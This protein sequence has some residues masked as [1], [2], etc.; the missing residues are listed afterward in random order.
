M[1]RIVA[2]AGAAGGVGTTSITLGL[3]DAFHRRGLA[4]QAFRAG[5]DLVTR[6]PSY[7][8]DGWMCGRDEIMR[9]M[10]RDAA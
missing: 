4:V 9:T 5:P 3:L 8:L 7:N 2:V 1:S 6:R 10:A